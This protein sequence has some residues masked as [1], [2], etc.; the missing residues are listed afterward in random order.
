M[1]TMR[2]ESMRCTSCKR[3]KAELKKKKSKLI[4][5][6]VMFLCQSCVDARMEPRGFVILAGR[7]G[8]DIAY[9]IKPQRY[10]GEPITLRELQ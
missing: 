5:S 7:E 1:T 2:N 10:V 9:W 8:K 6:A 4:P 3:H